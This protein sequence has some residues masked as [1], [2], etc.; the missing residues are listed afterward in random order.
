MLALAVG[1]L[2]VG[3]YAA[4]RVLAVKGLDWADKASS[5]ASAVLALV[6][7]VA[8]GMVRLWPRAPVRRLVTERDIGQAADD[9]AAA[10]DRRWSGEERLR[11]IHDPRPFPIRWEVTASAR[12]ATVGS[13]EQD[14]EAFGWY[15]EVFGFFTGLPARRAVFLG[16]AG[17]GKSVLA[18]K[19]ARELLAA[20]DAG[21]PVPAI[22]PAGEW[23]PRVHLIRWLADQLTRDYAGLAEEV[24]LGTGETGRVADLLVASGRVTP[25]LDGFDELPEA[26]RAGAIEQING[27]GSDRPL[28]VTSRPD[29]YLDAVRHGGRGVVAATVVELCPL[30]LAEAK[31][32]LREATATLPDGRWDPVTARLDAD[33]DGPLAAALT[34]PL[35]LWLA[36]TIYE[37]SDND[38]AEL[39]AMARFADRA[40]IENH[41]LDMF[42]PAVY[43]PRAYRGGGPRPRYP[44]RRATR[45]L[46]FL[47]AHL[48]RT[49]TQE[50]AWWRLYPAR[51]GADGLGVVVRL[52]LLGG[53]G[54]ALMRWM[55]RGYEG[56]TGSMPWRRILLGGPVGRYLRAPLDPAIA[57]LDGRIGDGLAPVV[58]ELLRPNLLPWLIV[59]LLARAR[60]ADEGPSGDEPKTLAVAPL[61]AFRRLVSTLWG[62]VGIDGIGLMVYLFVG[63]R[64]APEDIGDLLHVAWL[65]MN[66]A[67]VVL[68]LLLFV[69]RL[70]PRWL[71]LRVPVATGSP[72]A[73]PPTGAEDPAPQRP[74]DAGLLS[75]EELLRLDRRADLATTLLGRLAFGTVLALL[76]AGRL[77]VAYAV[78]ASAATLVAV[79]LGGVNRA[80]RRY[81]DARQSLFL[82]GWLPLRPMAFL[83]DAHR[84]GVLRR[85][86]PVYQFRHIRLQENLAA[87][88]PRWR[89]YSQP[90]PEALDRWAARAR[91]IGGAWMRRLRVWVAPVWSARS[92]RW[93][94]GVARAAG[95]AARA[96][97]DRMDLD[98]ARERQRRESFRAARRRLVGRFW[99]TATPP[100]SG[101]PDVDD[102]I[103]RLRRL[104]SVRLG[105]D[106]VGL[107]LHGS[108]TGGDF[109][110]QRSDIDLLAVVRSLPD[111]ATRRAVNTL[112]G[113]APLT[114]GTGVDLEW[115]DQHDLHARASLVPPEPGALLTFV[116]APVLLRY[117]LR[118]RGRAIAGPP[119]R[120]LIPAVSG[121]EYAAALAD[122]VAALSRMDWSGTPDRDRR[123]AACIANHALRVR[124]SD[125]ESLVVWPS[126]PVPAALRPHA[127][128]VRAALRW[129]GVA[130]E[131]GVLAQILAAARDG[132]AAPVPPR[133]T[134]VPHS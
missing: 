106:L 100:V 12:A 5:V 63:A 131:P 10:L 128:A 70:L 98:D 4:G 39:A 3:V 88:H 99:S 89:L 19:L 66:R 38:P 113:T 65:P 43:A 86:G 17:A 26:L 82:G 60:S 87:R 76:V 46:A 84:R 103:N 81:R 119:P 77:A 111:E 108:L 67:L 133:P 7:L 83:A 78:F 72:A 114:R 79:L 24:R 29:E 53:L 69:V 126:W 134:R 115:V 55:V 54:W 104:L 21:D 28:L 37:D 35:L 36:R 73:G 48:E 50:L 95:A 116:S 57:W 49:G 74:A 11:R 96:T 33:P 59:G 45:W 129:R 93:L 132:L 61:A 123:R 58:D 124:Q 130:P 92:V 25:V 27:L 22:V 117:A 6:G 9:L 15:G 102:L 62:L 44:A 105:P 64:K 2:A 47:A 56:Y 41:L 85:T 90:A 97:G 71:V 34:T 94:A 75:P 107:Y 125:Q 32:Y 14:R 120:S 40:A 118:A 20:R 42:V 112:L 1:V 51:A 18:M 30:R 91:R 13:V 23:D 31:A 16:S 110:P 52:V 109:D 80:N 122:H 68:A 101:Y 127:R 121:P 8:A